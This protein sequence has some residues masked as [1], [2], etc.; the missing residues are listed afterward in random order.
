MG[1]RIDTKYSNAV[2]GIVKYV[3]HDGVVVLECDDP[4][5][6]VTVPLCVGDADAIETAMFF[7]D[8]LCCIHD[9]KVLPLA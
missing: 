9:G 6:H 3:N 1:T 2:V 4:F 7:V 8:K 5:D